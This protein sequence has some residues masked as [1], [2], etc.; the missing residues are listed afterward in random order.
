MATTKR[1]AGTDRRPVVEGLSFSDDKKQLT[2][3]VLLCGK[4]KTGKTYFAGSFPKPII[5]NTDK[6]TTTL[7]GKHIPIVT[8]DRVDTMSKATLKDTAFQR[9]LSYADQFGEGEGDL[10]DALGTYEP[11]TIVIDSLSQL[12]VLLEVDVLTF[13][14]NNKE[15][16]GELQIQD[17]KTVQNRMLKIIDRFRELPYN[18]V[19]TSGID[20]IT[21]QDERWVENPM[22]SGNK[23][24]PQIP[25]HFDEVYRMMYDG[26]K[27]QWELRVAQST[28]FEHSG[29]RYGV[30]MDESFTNPTY[31]DLKQYYK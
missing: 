28:R 22:A 18:I 29:S 13:P 10:I 12:S 4:P 14:P 5:L 11:E 3:K 1:P 31:D 20:L 27:N 15:R 21:S 19:C 8:I 16:G 24:G 2:V 23:L 17:Y 25:H 30:P 7:R 26:K 9:M 6:G